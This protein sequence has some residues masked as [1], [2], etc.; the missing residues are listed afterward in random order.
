[1]IWL[2]IAAAALQ[3]TMVSPLDAG[4]VA[5]SPAAIPVELMVMTEVSTS[6]ARAGDIVKLRVNRPVERDGIVIVQPG[7][8][9]FGEVVSVKGSG[10]AMKRGALAIRLT[11]LVIDGRSVPLAGEFDARGR[12]GKG[13]DVARIL[14]APIYAPFASGNAAKFKAGEIISGQLLPGDLIR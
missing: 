11:R 8:A 4:T 10:A 9:A 13:D 14:L 12:G 5:P 2:A 1:M 3:G 7:T 6:R